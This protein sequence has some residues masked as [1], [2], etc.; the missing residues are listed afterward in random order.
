VAE[1][2]TDI[3]DSAQE[4]SMQSMHYANR[5]ISRHDDILVKL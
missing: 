4:E 2:I 1:D 5:R 3:H